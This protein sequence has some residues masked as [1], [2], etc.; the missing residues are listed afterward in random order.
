M[1]VDFCNRALDDLDEIY[2]LVIDEI[3][4]GNLSKILGELMLLIEPD[5]RSTKWAVLAPLFVR[6]VGR[7]RRGVEPGSAESIGGGLAARTRSLAKRGLDRGYQTDIGETRNP[8]GRFLFAESMKTSS[9]IAGKLV[10]RFDELSADVTHNR[11]LKAAITVL[12]RSDDLEASRSVELRELRGKLA[13]VTDVP[14]SR[15]LFGRLQLSR[16]IAHYGLLMKICE[17]VLDLTMPE[18][19]GKGSRFADILKDES[20][21]SAIFEVFVRNFFERE[22]D[23]F[24]VSS[25]LIAWDTGPNP[26]SHGQYLPSM[27]TDVTLRSPTRTIVLDAKFYRETLVSHFGGQKKVRSAHLYQILSYLKNVSRRPGRTG[28]P[29]ACCSTHPLMGTSFA[30][31]SS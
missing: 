22:Q 29:K 2:V 5:K 26:T 3:N 1:F 20:R 9:L 8:R 25:E 15:A 13:A 28:R 31:S 10:C 17:M 21:M 18:E 16:S 24:S 19:Q 27:L 4:R 12:A 14:L 23:H 30:L 7:G 6:S 11:I